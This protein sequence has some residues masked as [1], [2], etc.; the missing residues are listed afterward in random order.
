MA[1]ASPPARNPAS[2]TR[3]TSR[4]SKSIINFWLDC[5]LLVLFLGLVWASAVL[6]FLFPVG[7]RAMEWQLWGADIEGWRDLQF[8]ILC[9]FSLGVLLHV[10]LHWSWVCGVVTKHL[11]GR[12][13]TRDDGSQT[14][15]GVGVLLAILHLLAAGLLLA[16]YCLRPIA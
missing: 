2:K 5:L 4:W 13:P 16:W 9:L 14:L 1:P 6:R 12:P 7:P 15:L 8:V 10:M 3:T 11:L